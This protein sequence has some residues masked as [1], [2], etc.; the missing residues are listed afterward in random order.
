MN[1][2]KHGPVDM[3]GWHINAGDPGRDFYFPQGF[4][5]E[6]GQS[7]RVYRNETHLETCGFSFGSGQAIWNNKGD[8]GY[9]FDGQGQVV[10][11]RGY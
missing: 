2:I 4:V 1:P 6:P 3:T 5:M 10:S 8:T 9:L 7:C 11:E